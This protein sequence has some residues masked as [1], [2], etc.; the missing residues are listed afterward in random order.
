M[1][2]KILHGFW[3]F[4]NTDI[5]EFFTQATCKDYIT[6]FKTFFE[7][8]EVLD[9]NKGKLGKFPEQI[10]SLL[11]VLNSPMGEVVKTS[12]PFLSLVTG[13]LTF[14]VEKNKKEP[15]LE[16]C[17]ALVGQGAYLESMQDFLKEHP[18][19]PTQLNQKKA[20]KELQK[21]LQSQDLTLNK[22]EAKD[23]L[24][25]FHQSQ[26]AEGFN[27]LLEERFQEA[28]LTVEIAKRVTERISR[29][30]HRLLKLAFVEA[31]D[32]VKKLARLY[33]SEWE[34]EQK[35]YS[36]I[37][38]YLRE[39]IATKPQE[40]VFGE[41][42]SF[43]D[44]YVPLEVKPIKEE[45]IYKR[46]RAENI[47]HWATNRLQEEKVLFIQAGPGR[48]KS[49]FCRMF[50]DWVRR[51]LH[52][53]WIPI[54][55][56]LRDIGK[57]ESNFDETLK[58]AVPW[59]FAASDKGWLTDPNTRFLFLLDGFDELLLERGATQDL[60]DFLWQ[61]SQ[62]Q[63]DCKAN[64]KERGHKVIL[65]GRP[66]PL[67]GLERRMPVNFER[68]GI[69]PMSGE[70]QRQWLSRWEKVVDTD[71]SKAQEETENFRAFLQEMR[72]PQQV[73]ELAQEP[74]LLYMLATL[75]RD[76]VLKTDMFTED[77]AVDPKVL[78]YERAFDW[79]L[80]KQRCEGGENL[81]PR[82]TG[83][84]PED[85]SSILA[86]A[87]LCVVQSGREFASVVTIEDRLEEKEDIVAKEI[88]E[89]ARQRDEKDPLKNALA[90]F[91]IKNVSGA[92][93]C[94][95]F[96]HKSFSEFLCAKRM[97][98]SLKEWGE[99]KNKRGK[100]YEVSTKEMNWQ[101]Y[102]LFGYGVLTKEIVDYLTP[103]L[104]KLL[105]EV[106]NRE[107]GTGNS[108]RELNFVVLFER[109]NDFYL[110]WSDGEFIE[111][112]KETLPQRKTG[113]LQ[114]YDT[115]LGQRRVDIYTGL[116]VLILL[117]ELHR[118]GQSQ[119]A[120]KD[121]LAFHP[122]GQPNTEN[123]VEDRLLCLIN[124]SDC[125]GSGHFTSL[126]G[127]FFI[128][129]NLQRADLQQ[130]DLE[131][132]NLQR[133]N[134]QRA[135]LQRADLE[136]T[137]LQQV[138]LEGANLQRA[139]LQR[140]NLQRAKLQRA[141]L[142]G[143]DLEGAKLQRAKLQRAKLQRAKLQQV[144]LEGAKLLGAYLLGADLLGAKLQQ[145][146]LEG[147][148]LQGANL[149]GADLLGAKLQQVDLEGAN[150]RGAN[151]QRTK[152]RGANLEGAKLQ[153]AYL[154]E[155]DLLGVNLEGA[156]LLGAYLEG[157]KFGHNQGISEAMKADLI[158]RGAIF[159]D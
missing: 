137:K 38:D 145:V 95:E 90:A 100:P 146:D 30:T 115:D 139:K 157:A 10:N 59:D 76:N 121:K 133:A 9:K 158:K 26:L 99:R 79:V 125:L 106:G 33:G 154:Q 45:E 135:K 156:K 159:T 54:L 74:L 2:K 114:E 42:F 44:I 116:N 129:A 19:I 41:T 64:S 37:D 24:L 75:H 71:P 66:L 12:L 36:S 1:V 128:K 108:K 15:S 102:D 94:V 101:I 126:V 22:D 43:Q 147:A 85:L 7:L 69:L 131:E 52:P 11:D 148:K 13:I 20:S 8:A 134:L 140:A 151:L 25:C 65:T 138:D 23:V 152:L 132:A 31:G 96:F 142:E 150:L 123:F 29:S 153:R 78:I 120:L 143:A 72:C 17:I 47:E 5:T 67:A 73:K 50:A 34:T 62:F 117:L 16:E 141:D 70:I 27:L 3:D 98:E 110:R 84:E 35:I 14:Y 32:A 118:Y 130:V 105:T 86:E 81:N 53:I 112:A 18:K 48:G 136:G 6:A 113:Q 97:V 80:N 93:N 92:D 103:L 68:V 122:C 144:D 39:R 82:I 56:R 77:S 51:E 124:Y 58:K 104:I 109:L 88:L 89:E 57:P 61:V 127:K 60:K 83:L 21:K 46:A 111:S 28:G 107:Q 40:K 4:L 55:I 91:Y 155:A 149:L 63:K 87:G 119:E 49:V